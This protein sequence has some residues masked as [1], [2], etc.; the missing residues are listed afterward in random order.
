[1]LAELGLAKTLEATA[2]EIMQTI[3]AHP[4][5]SEVIKEA[6]E[7]AFGRPIHI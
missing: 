6:T 4:T 3:H 5:V 2:D 1:M 7:E